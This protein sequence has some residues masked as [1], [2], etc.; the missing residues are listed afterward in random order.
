MSCARERAKVCNTETRRRARFLT[1]AC[2]NEG[3]LLSPAAFETLC[4][5]GLG[6]VV[7]PGETGE[8]EEE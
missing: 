6:T 4:P 2:V 3:I 8:G 1:T 7:G 5:Y